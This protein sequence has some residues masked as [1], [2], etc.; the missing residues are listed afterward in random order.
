MRSYVIYLGA[1]AELVVA[2]GCGS[3]PAAEGHED[4][5]A[6]SS[7]LIYGT[8]SRT[9]YLD[10][11]DTQLRMK[12]D[13]T[14]AVVGLGGLS[15]NT[16]ACQLIT[17]QPYATGDVELDPALSLPL[18]DGVR[19]KGQLGEPH[20]TAFLVGPDT[21]ATAG[22]CLATNGI[23]STVACGD[24]RAVFGFNANSSGNSP[25]SI[26]TSNVYTCTNI[27][28]KYTATE[29]W[30]IFKVDRVVSG[31]TP[32]IVQHTGSQGALLGREI[33]SFGHGFK[34]PLKMS[35][36]ATVKLDSTTDLVK[37]GASTDI[38][39]GNSGGPGTDLLS[40]VVFG[41]AVTAPAIAPHV[42]TPDGKGGQCAALRVCSDTAG[43]PGWS[44]YTRMTY[45]TQQA[46]T[47][48][49]PLHSALVSAITLS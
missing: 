33:V 19:F 25:S 47:V 30:A 2:S 27:Q 23:N 28:G 38:V 18:C 4:L 3:R 9:E 48:I 41:I 46:T 40:G 44:G 24:A 1:L 11:V 43:C 32:M 45:V 34:L 13:A 31:R 49:V 14:A 39:G 35:T 6:Q 16:S 22:H 5:A 21:F 15:C 10:I 17:L 7:P 29:D 8:D 20:C 12:A 26:P 37:F 36:G 42:S